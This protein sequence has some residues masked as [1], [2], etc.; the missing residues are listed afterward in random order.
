MEE[1]SPLT[2]RAY[3]KS[4]HTGRSSPESL[5]CVWKVP[6]DIALLHLPP[7]SD[8][9]SNPSNSEVETREVEGDLRRQR[10]FCSQVTKLSEMRGYRAEQ[11]R[12][13]AVRRKTLCR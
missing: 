9:T 2:S 6:V 7:G 12:G 5:T 11:K 13:K 10:R 3:R 1:G 4:A 8:S